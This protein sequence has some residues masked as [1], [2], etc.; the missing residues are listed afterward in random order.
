MSDKEKILAECQGT[1]AKDRAVGT[2]IGVFGQ[3]IKDGNPLLRRRLEKDSLYQQDLSG[4][5][6]MT[7]G[8]AEI[9]HFASVASAEELVKKYQGSIFNTIAQELREESGL[10]LLDLPGPL[11]M[12]PAWLWRPYTD[13]ETKEERITI[14]LA[15]SIPIPWST[16]IQE[17]QVFREKLEKGEVMFVPRDKLSEIEIVGPRMRFLIEQALRLYDILY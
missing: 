7:G 6:E 11:L 17:T 12:A 8:G 16:A 4:K 5:W 13:K 3:V 9:Q 2:G 1:L 15:F 10:E 14:D